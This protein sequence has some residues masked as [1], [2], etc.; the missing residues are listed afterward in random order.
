M[1]INNCTKLLLIVLLIFSSFL[2]QAQD[3]KS[4][5]SRRSKIAL[6]DTTKAVVKPK[7]NPLKKIKPYESVINKDFKSQKGLFNVHQHRDTIYFEIPDSL[8][9]RD[10]MVINRLK[11]VPG[12]FDM[13]AGE[14]LDE[15]L[16]QFELGPDSSIRVRFNLILNEADPKSNISKAVLASNLNP[17]IATFPIIAYAKDSGSYVIDV[18]KFLTEYNFINSINSTSP[19]LK[20]LSASPLKDTYI[21]SIRA[22]P[23]NVEIGISKSLPGKQAIAGTGTVSL[24]TSTS[25]IVLPK[26]PMQRRFF[27]KRV[28]Y[29]ARQYN[30]FA[31][32]QHHAESK[33]FISRWRLEP[34]DQDIEKWKKGELVEPKKPIVIYIDPAT[35]KQWVPFLIAG[36][37]D[38]QVAFE[39]AGFKNAVVG[40]AWPENDSNMHMD[41]ARYSVLNYLPSATSNAYGPHVA[42]PRSG[43]IIQTH[44]GWYH[45]IM[46]LLNQWYIIQA[47]ANDPE[48][49]KAK[50]DDK[51]MG[52][53]IR[54][55]SS[56]EVGHTLG[57][58]H[59]FG[60]S[61]KTP[62]D[63][64]RSLSYLKKYGH[65]ASMMD[66][67][68]F[69]YVAQPEDHIPQEYLFPKIGDYDKWAIEWGYKNS[70]AANA[71]EDQ[72]IVNQW[73]V[74][75]VSAN[76]RLWFGDGETEYG[77]PRS[78]TEDL[79]DN[80]MKASV[81]GIKNLKRI[82]PKLKNWVYEK[83]ADYT[84]LTKIHTELATQYNR[85]LNHVLKNIGGVNRNYSSQGQNKAVYTATPRK[86]Q[87][88]A[89]QFFDKELFT[90]PTWLLN[91]DLEDRTLDPMYNGS[92][93]PSG[94]HFVEDFQVKVLNTLLRDGFLQNIVANANRFGKGS[95][96]IDDHLNALHKMIWRDLNPAQ[97]KMD[98]SRR[99]MQKSYVGSLIAILAFKNVQTS[100]T[101]VPSIA[102]AELK[103]IRISIKNAIPKTQDSITKYH[104]IDMQERIDKA[105]Y[106][107]G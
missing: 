75:R 99:N 91:K 40:K 52:E 41:D 87:L 12:N 77:D 48:A 42:D 102:K 62:V 10:I 43:E 57:L 69:N 89:M 18:T 25:F 82:L 16:I 61:S 56:H 14:Q 23:L 8:L 92:G 80:A 67:A 37:E 36:I 1:K 71:D 22:Y 50:L 74:D 53:L 85:Y 78:Q 79:G 7:I 45:N 105:L 47:G 29:F 104:L 66:Y 64:L 49:R 90:T 19:L 59:N 13:F 63:S 86:M 4:K 46:E 11:K 9:K 58:R 97:I 106:V 31:D 51:L 84:N 35:P 5:K 54:F 38:W 70:F 93:N 27:D 26:T 83:D 20:K 6:S 39:K 21:E 32:D 107:K 55:V 30:V 98:R 44:I 88:E 3:K 34:K 28:G 101:D 96:T 73:I 68:R 17:L 2:A 60:S 100:E 65:T 95:Y 33:Q 94:A 76:P 24:E 81:Y 15:N 72:K 103:R